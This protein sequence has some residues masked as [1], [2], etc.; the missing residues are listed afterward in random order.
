MYALNFLLVIDKYNDKK[1]HIMTQIISFLLKNRL[2]IFI[3]VLLA[4][5]AG[6]WT[7]VYV[8]KTQ[9]ATLTA[10]KITLNTL[11]AQSQANLQQLHNDIAY[12][13]DM[14]AKFKAEADAR[15]KR[16]A[17]DV[18]KAKDEAATYKAKADAL[19][20]RRLPVNVPVCDAAR[21]LILE[22]IN[23]ARN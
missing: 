17:A 2:T 16:N 3:A 23:N 13:N 6:Q 7:Y 4:A 22:E 10:E 18:K 20:A 9:R 5:F 19:L 8:L 21:D 14:I 15:V 11:L 12:Q 1:V